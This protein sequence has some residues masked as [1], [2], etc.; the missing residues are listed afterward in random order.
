MKYSIRTANR[1]DIPSLITVFQAAVRSTAGRG[2][3]PEQT[4]AWAARGTSA[5]FLELFGSG[6][7]FFTAEAASGCI[8]FAAVSSAGFLHSLFVGPELQRK[9]VAR[10]LLDSAVLFA[11]EHGAD[12]M[13]AEVSVAALP[14][15]RG[16]GFALLREQTVCLNG[17]A[18]T[19]Y[20]MRLQL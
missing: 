13:G 2:Y 11:Q 3:T 18:L 6:M 9:G 15:F 5:R 17:I 10:A 14:F 20:R 19:N 12:H 4:E 1:E 7:A 8:G 16:A